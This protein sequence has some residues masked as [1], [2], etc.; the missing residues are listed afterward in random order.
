MTLKLRKNYPAY[1]STNEYLP[2]I[3]QGLTPEAKD[4]I[5][6]IGGSGDQAFALL[7][8]VQRVRI[9]DVDQSQIDLIRERAEALEKKDYTGFVTIGV[10]TDRT[11]CIENV[12]RRN[13]YFDRER[14]LRIAAK[15]DHFQISEGKDISKDIRR[16]PK[17]TFTKLYLSNAWWIKPRK[18]N[19]DFVSRLG[20]SL[21][22]GGLI[23]YTCSLQ[24][25]WKSAAHPELR[26]DEERTQLAR[27]LEE[28]NNPF[29]RWAPTVLEKIC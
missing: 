28:N 29:N 26:I 19:S 10:P 9:V 15:L 24:L 5:L 22:I 17:K 12:D 16:F 6:C 14:F 7:E 3:I 2:A 21:P 4:S 18:S 20:E 23:Y 8:H 25:N 13:N 11:Y 1:E 27:K